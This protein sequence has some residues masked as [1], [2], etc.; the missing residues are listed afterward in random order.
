MVVPAMHESMYRHP[1]VVENVAKLKGWGIS[2]V[3]PMFAEGIA[4]IASNEEIVL[5]VER[6]LGNRS[7]ENRKVL[8]TGGST[9][10]SLDPI[11]ILTNRRITSYNVCYTKLLRPM[12]GG[13]I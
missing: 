1:A 13:L 9:A 10:E 11:R 4:K 8:I 5:E 6:A 2:M 7:L 3:G 12:T